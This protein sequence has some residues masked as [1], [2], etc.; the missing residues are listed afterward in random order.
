MKV[1]LSQDMATV[2]D[3]YVVKNLFQSEQDSLQVKVRNEQ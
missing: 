1:K 2:G 3:V